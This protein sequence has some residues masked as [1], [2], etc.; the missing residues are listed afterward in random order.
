[1]NIILNSVVTN[2][3]NHP[4]VEQKLTKHEMC[5]YNSTPPLRRIL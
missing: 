5:G 1:M 2:V 4:Y 3:Q